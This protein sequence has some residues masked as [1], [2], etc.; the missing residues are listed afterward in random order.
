MRSAHDKTLEVVITPTHQRRL[1][2]NISWIG[3][4]RIASSYTPL[5]GSTFVQKSCRVRVPG[6]CSRTILLCRLW[7]S[8]RVG[9]P[10]DRQDDDCNDKNTRACFKDWY[11]TKD[12]R[13]DVATRHIHDLPLAGWVA[14]HIAK[15]PGTGWP[16]QH[17]FL[18]KTS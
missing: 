14:I 4:A 5:D 9:C 1:N 16:W 8:L 2:I 12:R 15:Y 18:A 11:E 17:S 13:S 6:F 3:S 10:D 7:A